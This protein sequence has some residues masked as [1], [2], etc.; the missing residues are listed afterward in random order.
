[1]EKKY[2]TCI[3][4]A[5]KI[6]AEPFIRGLGLSVKEKKPI[7]VF[8]GRDIVLSI[9]G[10]GKS[11]AA[12]AATNLING[13][14]P[15]RIINLGAAGALN[16]NFM[17]GDILHI[18]KIIEPDRPRLISHKP[19]VHK[20]DTLEGF[21]L[22]SL[23]THDRPVLTQQDRARAGKLAELV[24]MEGAAIVQACRAFEIKAFLFKIVTDTASSGKM[25]IIKN[26]IHTRGLL[27]HF[28]IEKIMPAID[29]E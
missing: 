20:P 25:E 9:S 18:D 24:D 17:I 5:T 22:A 10:I 23:A 11:N 26:I 3:L 29:A 19:E 28:F 13:Y 2:V 27:F 21:D 12:I 6:E 4:M 7:P 16:N 1:M 14:G 8:E 15:K